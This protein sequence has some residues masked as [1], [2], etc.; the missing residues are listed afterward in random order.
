M[1]R[2]LRWAFDSA[3][4]VSAVLFVTVPWVRC[5][6]H[7]ESVHLLDLGQGWEVVSEFSDLKVDNT[8]AIRAAKQARDNWDD[9]QAPRPRTNYA[10]A[11]Y[12]P[13]LP[14]PQALPRPPLP[15][16]V[17]YSLNYVVLA[18]SLLLL[19]LLRLATLLCRRRL[20]PAGFCPNCGYDLRA[21]PD[22]C[23]ECGSVPMPRQ[24]DP[25]NYPNVT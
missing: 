25:I 2:L 14:G 5:S 1:R 19:P 10:L 17:S 9:G 20:R 7:A 12:P 6:W 23:P 24:P 22:R 16:A 15:D 8:P 4:A 11:S 3:A 13:A 21:T 18:A